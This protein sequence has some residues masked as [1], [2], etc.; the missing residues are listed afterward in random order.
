MRSIVIEVDGSVDVRDLEGY[1]G[2]SSALK[3]DVE[4]IAGPRE[5]IA[6]YCN[7]VGKL[8]GMPINAKATALLADYLMH[9]DTINGPLVICGIDWSTGYEQDIPENF[10]PEFSKIL[11]EHV[12]RFDQFIEERIGKEVIR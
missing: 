10:I 6:C 9:G 2:I 5:D 12:D 1:E 7:D 4:L 3:G 8:I 11:Y